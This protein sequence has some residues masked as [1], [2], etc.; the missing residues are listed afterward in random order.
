[1]GVLGNENAAYYDNDIGDEAG[2]MGD[3]LAAVNLG[4][5]NT[6]LKT[7]FCSDNEYIA[8]NVCTVCPAGESNPAGDEQ[9]GADTTCSCTASTDSSKGVSDGNF[10]CI[11]GGTVDGAAGFYAC[12]SCDAGYEGDNCQTAILCAANERVAS[13]ACTM[14]AAG[15]INAAGDDSSGA[16][17]KCSA[18]PPASNS[19]PVDANTRETTNT[20]DV[21]ELDTVSSASCLDISI[22]TI[23]VVFATI[24]AFATP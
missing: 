9:N 17:T 15:T 19:S 14:C 23:G 3:N 18:N 5:G 1:M 16:D 12:A 7:V 20:T 11:N 4:T 10:Y 13:K 8:S 24:V 2:E 6:V 21:L 22:A